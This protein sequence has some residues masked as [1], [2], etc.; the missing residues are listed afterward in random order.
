MAMSS[1]CTS[2]GSA[3]VRNVLASFFYIKPKGMSDTFPIKSCNMNTT[4]M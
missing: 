2:M 1:A 3:E 4:S